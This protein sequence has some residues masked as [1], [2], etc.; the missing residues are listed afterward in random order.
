MSEGKHIYSLSSYLF[1][2]QVFGSFCVCDVLGF[3]GPGATGYWDNRGCISF[4]GFGG[5]RAIF[6]EDNKNYGI[7]FL[8]LV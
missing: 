6:L 4:L 7:A 5:Y 1:H 2:T 8:V 3:S